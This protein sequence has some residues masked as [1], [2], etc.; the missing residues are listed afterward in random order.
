MAVVLDYLPCPKCKKP[1]FIIFNKD[2][3]GVILLCRECGYVEGKIKDM[4][5]A[6]AYLN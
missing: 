5:P 2:T 1:I 4:S 3:K 6:P